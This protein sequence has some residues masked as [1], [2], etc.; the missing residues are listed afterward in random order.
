MI[1]ETTDRS[2]VD[3][4]SAVSWKAIF[5]GSTASLAITLILLAFGIGVGFSVVSP[6]AGS[7]ISATTFTI[8][9]GVYFIVVAM[10]SSTIGGYIAGRLRSQWATV[11]MHERYFRDTAHGFLVWA[12]AT[13]ISAVVLGGAATHILSGASAGVVPAAT[14]GASGSPTDVYVDTLL[15]ANPAA[16]TAASST[17]G[18]GNGQSNMNGVRGQITRILMP[19]LRKGG[20]LSA[21]DRT[22]V[23]KVV[24]ARTGLPQPEAEKRVDQVVTQARAAT[25]AARKSAAKFSL[26]LVVS[27]LAGALS[28]SLAA[29]EGGRLR[30]SEWYLTAK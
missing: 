9:A 10:L 7:G 25:D 30:N 1:T 29:V 3:D 8:A 24:S 23:A 19:S 26:W 21:A 22:Y 27:M 6:W 13:V 15:R 5:A 2:L 4:S 20:A 17:A 16:A 11:H 18:Q 12:F 14:V 28:A